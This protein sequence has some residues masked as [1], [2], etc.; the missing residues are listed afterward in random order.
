MT[1]WSSSPLPCTEQAQAG[2]SERGAA[3]KTAAPLLLAP[4]LVVWVKGSK[5]LGHTRFHK[6]EKT[7]MLSKFWGSQTAGLCH[8]VNLLLL[9]A[10]IVSYQKVLTNWES[11]DFDFGLQKYNLFRCLHYLVAKIT[12]FSTLLAISTNVM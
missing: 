9:I 5:K 10:I 12:I 8:Y 4:T 2:S 3:G 1:E 11:F 6:Q 7:S